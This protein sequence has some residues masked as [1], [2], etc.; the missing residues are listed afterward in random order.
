MYFQNKFRVAIFGD[1]KWCL[2]LLK[3]ISKDRSIEI[4]FICGRYKKDINLSQLA[5][6]LKIKFIKPKNINSD[7]MIKFVKESNLNLCVSMSYDQ[8][9]KK[10][11]IK[12]INNRIYNCHAGLLPSYRGRNVLNW[13]LING[14][15]FYGVT[16]HKVNHYI[17]GGDIM[18]QKKIKIFN[19]WEYK[20]ILDS[21]YKHC[22]NICFDGIKKL[23]KG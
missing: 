10:K 2:N 14:E 8:I 11:F 12:T 6:S 3:K 15:K 18:L 7:Q 21:A 9:F 4:I 17:D 19:S 22:A 23:Q 20:E 13:A 16:F 1:N 5:K